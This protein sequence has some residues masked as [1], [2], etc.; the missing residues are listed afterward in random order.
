MCIQNPNIKKFNWAILFLN[1]TP[2][3]LN[4][5]LITIAHTQ[6]CRGVSCMHLVK[7]HSGVEQLYYC[8]DNH[9]PETTMKPIILEK[10]NL[11]DH[12]RAH[13]LILK[14]CKTLIENN[15]PKFVNF[16]QDRFYADI[17]V[18]NS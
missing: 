7:F 14:R 6:T 13:D 4:S 18:L 1:K 3:G 12:N 2:I 16:F 5:H 17:Y 11:E 8:K 15:F 9:L 10:L